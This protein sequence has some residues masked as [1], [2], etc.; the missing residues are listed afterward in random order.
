MP[1]IGNTSSIDGD[2]EGD[3]LDDISTEKE[4]KISK[5]GGKKLLPTTKSS[6]ETL[7]ENVGR[8]QLSPESLKQLMLSLVLGMQTRKRVKDKMNM[9]PPRIYID[10]EVFPQP[11]IK[12]RFIYTIHGLQYIPAL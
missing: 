12:S 4:N 8:W 2:T 3:A 7:T 6:P 10:N 9:K 5:R 1:R 11:L